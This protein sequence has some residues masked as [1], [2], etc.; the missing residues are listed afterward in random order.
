[1]EAEMERILKEKQLLEK[2]KAGLK[3][4]QKLG[5][6]GFWELDIPTGRL[7]WSDETY[8][9]FQTPKSFNP[10]FEGFLA[11]IHPEDREIVER[12][13][14]KSV[15]RGRPYTVNHRLLLE[16]ETLKFVKES[17]V[18]EYDA[19]GEP[20]RSFGTVL[21]ITD[22][23]EAQVQRRRLLTQTI[24]ALSLTLEKR[25]PYTSGHQLRVA[26]L[27]VQIGTALGWDHARNTGLY[28]GAMLHDIGKIYIPS[29]ILNRPGRLSRTEFELIKTHP[30]VGYDIISAI[31]Y[32]WPIGDF[33]LQHHERMD[34]SG[35]PF[36]LRGEEISEEA[37]VIAVADVM[38]AMINHRPFRTAKGKDF[39]LAELREGLG[40]RYDPLIG[41]ACARI[42][43]QEDFD[44]TVINEN[45]LFLKWEMA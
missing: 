6:L 12:E 1:M 27:S 14:G 17:G 44:F 40:T 26:G 37:R 3:M 7:Y 18:T 41:E 15:A 38:E 45:E 22:Q 2:E 32:P 35:Y 5:H 25:D 28:F 43:L 42:V 30:Q 36:G 13:Y 8:H 11:F 23:I 9:I 39:A 29:E 31:D 4:A 19:Q 33:V 20:R 10:T 16:G 24:K 21:D 34:G